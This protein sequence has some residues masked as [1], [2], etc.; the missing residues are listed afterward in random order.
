M[1]RH[2]LQFET[3]AESLLHDTFA[4]WLHDALSEHDLAVRLIRAMDDGRRRGPRGETL[5]PD[6]YVLL[7]HPADLATLQRGGQAEVERARRNR[8]HAARRA[9]CSWLPR[10]VTLAAAPEQRPRRNVS[11]DQRRPKG[12][13]AQSA[14]AR[15]DRRGAARAS[16]RRSA[17]G[18][19]CR[20]TG[21]SSPWAGARTTT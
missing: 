19:W 5:V 6:R 20:S 17:G 7:L 12:T 13:L 4:R 10:P 2:L 14:V 3:L 8:A 15:G 9:G 16:V 21:R 11:G 18:A 1:L